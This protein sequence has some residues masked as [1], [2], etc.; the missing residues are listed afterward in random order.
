MIIYYLNHYGNVSANYTWNESESFENFTLL[1][2]CVTELL[3]TAKGLATSLPKHGLNSDSY[4]PFHAL[5]YD[6]LINSKNV[7]LTADTSHAAVGNSTV[8][9][10][11]DPNDIFIFMLILILALAVLILI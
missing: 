2:F 9:E 10:T 7:N 8:G 4:G 1:D 5:F 3:D 11:Q 6:S